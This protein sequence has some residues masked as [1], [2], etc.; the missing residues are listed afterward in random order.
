FLIEKYESIQQTIFERL[1]TK[2][3]IPNLNKLSFGTE[4]KIASIGL[5]QL[6]CSD[7]M[8]QQYFQYWP[9]LLSGI[10]EILLGLQDDTVP[11]DFESDVFGLEEQ[12]GFTS[13]FQQL[14]YSKTG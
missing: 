5:T 4:R 2:I 6:L 9:D 8:L 13:V 12:G 11:N 3:I 1:L 7:I 10:L 14:A